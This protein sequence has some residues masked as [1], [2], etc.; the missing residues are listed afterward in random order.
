MI[1]KKAEAAIKQYVKTTDPRDVCHAQV[2]GYERKA[3]LGPFRLMPVIGYPR[4]EHGVSI[5]A[6]SCI[7]LRVYDDRH[8]GTLGWNLPFN[9]RTERTI[10]GLLTSLGWDGRV[11]PFDAGWPDDTPEATGLHVLLID[12]Q[13]NA[14]LVFP[15][16]ERG[17]RVLRVEVQ[18]L[19]GDFALAPVVPAEDYIEP[20]EEN[21]AKLR[22]IVADADMFLKAPRAVRK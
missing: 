15:P 10:C 20:T 14:T 8:M 22:Q 1:T 11:W 19:S 7:M 4:T 17:S 5:I 3:Q 2:V 12:S 18:K 16:E 6:L 21:L 13:V 9:E